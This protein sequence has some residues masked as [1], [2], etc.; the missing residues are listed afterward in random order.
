[1]RAIVVACLVWG[2]VGCGLSSKSLQCADDLV[3]PQDQLCDLAHHGCADVDQFTA[4]DGKV[5]GED[6]TS[7]AVPGGT[8]NQGVCLLARCGD[9]VVQG[10]EECDRDADTLTCTDFGYYDDGDVACTESCTY[11]RIESRTGCTGWCGDGE[12]RIGVELCDDALGPPVLGCVDLGYGAGHLG[13][14]QCGPGIEDCKLFGWAQIAMPT[15]MSDVHGTDDVNVFAVSYGSA[16]AVHFDG[17]AWKPV[18]LSACALSPV[19]GF[20]NVWTVGPAEAFA[21]S[22]SLN[23]VYQL[24]PG[25][26]VKHSFTAKPNDV[27]GTSPTNVYVAAD[28]G[29]HHWDGSSWMQVDATART[30]IWGSSA[31]D[32][33]AGGANNVL[34]H[35]DGA[36][37][38]SPSTSLAV[39]DVV[40]IWGTGAG[41]VYLAGTNGSTNYVYRYNGS[42]WTAIYNAIS[43]YDITTGTVAFGHVLIGF[44]ASGRILAY[45]GTRWTLIQ[46]QDSYSTTFGMWTSPAGRVFAGINGSP[47]LLAFEGAVRIDSQ[48]YGPS[49]INVGARSESEVY[50]VQDSGADAGTLTRWDGFNWSPEST[51]GQ[52]PKDVWVDP[53]GYVLVADDKG[54][55]I[56][57]G[58]RV[59]N[60]STGLWSLVSGSTAANGIWGTSRLDYWTL[61]GIYDSNTNTTPVTMK[62]Y[63][64]NVVS[65]CTGCPSPRELRDIGGTASNN[66]I[67]V[68]RLGQIFR[69]NGTSVSQMTSGTT[70][71]LLTIGVS[72]DGAHVW[73]GGNNGTLLH[74]DGTTWT[75]VATPNKASPIH[76]V[77]GTS[78][79]DLFIGQTGLMYHFDGMYWS[80]V[81]AATQGNIKGMESIGDTLMYIDGA[82]PPAAMLHQ[83]VRIKPW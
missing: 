56:A 43:N 39:A 58:V 62:H 54:Q 81:A 44:A 15:R 49:A 7:A 75:L 36:S 61:D 50:V 65:V 32:I 24:T 46:V 69:Y 20:A 5:D 16:E 31:T 55:T 23:E 73:A 3:C 40:S 59:K 21:T 66:V 70:E 11:E 41:D 34:R 14:N 60:P 35:Y 2:C 76:S 71:D 12:I 26:C 77:W 13:C 9:G 10:L 17:I 79:S 83:L 25:G 64:N 28:N 22:R 80:Q 67:A 47:V 29:I 18:D 4:C 30:R 82:G 6:C 74:F 8:C 45:D 57:G 48:P 1:M 51:G 42:G 63:V 53:S 27:W 37:W 52:N 78:P 19:A 33:W 72:P 38:T 68:G